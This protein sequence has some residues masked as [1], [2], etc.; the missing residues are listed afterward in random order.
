MFTQ[1]IL[2]QVA[3]LGI[4]IRAVTGLPSGWGPWGGP[5]PAKAVYVMTN[6]VDS[7][8]IIAMSVGNDGSLSGG[9][10]TA[11]GGK[12]GNLIG[13]DGMPD[14]PDALSVQDSVNSAG[15]VSFWSAR[16]TQH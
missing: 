13:A 15:N 3:L 2:T 11:T 14:F 8:A 6:D 12:G 5:K 4:S 7:N 1:Q 16:L 9:S 10:T